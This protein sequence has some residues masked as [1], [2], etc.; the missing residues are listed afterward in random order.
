MLKPV[1]ASIN[2]VRIKRKILILYFFGILLPITGLV[3]FFSYQIKSELSRREQTLVE[4]ELTR[5]QLNIS[6]LINTA[7]NLATT[8]FSDKDLAWA[9]ETYSPSSKDSLTTIRSIDEQVLSNLMVHPFM[10]Q[11]NIYFDNEN[12]FETSY[13]H[14]LSEET[15]QTA[16]YQSFLASGQSTYLGSGEQKTQTNLY[17]I[18]RLN[19]LKYEGHNLIKIDISPDYIR[20]YFDSELLSRERCRI[21]LVTPD[22]LIALSNITDYP[23]QFSDV[24]FRKS[25]HPYT[26]EFDRSS[27]LSGWKIVA[28]P[29]RSL[30]YSSLSNQILFLIFAFLLVLSLSMLL[31]YGLAHSIIRRLEYMA[32]VMEQSHNDELTEIDIAMGS[33]EIGITAGCYNRMIQKV[34]ALMEDNSK[35]YQE[36]QSTNEELIATLEEIENKE[37]QIDE[38]VSVDKLTGLANRFSITR[39]IDNQFLEMKGTRSFAIGFLDIDNFKLINDSYGHDIGDDVIKQVGDRLNTFESDYIHTGRFG[40]D[41]FIITIK[42]YR[43]KKHLYKILEDIR[44]ALRE[45]IMLGG[46]S[47]TMTISMGVSLYGV[48][49]RRRHELIKLADIALYKAKEFGR[50]QIVFFESTMNQALSEKLKRQA[51]VREAVKKKEFVLFYQPYYDI[52]TR[53]MKGCEALLRWNSRCDF[54]ISTQEV[55]QYI[56]EMGL[57]IEFGFWIINEACAFAKKLNETRDTPLTVSINISALQLMQNDFI[58][59]VLQIIAKNKVGVEYIFLEMTESI[60]MDSIE[61]GFSMINRLQSA[62]ISISLDDFGTGYSS[63]KYF[64]ELPITTLKIDKSFIDHVTSNE[65]DEQLVDTMIQLA[66]NRKINVIAEGVE[67]PEQL[68]RLRK[69]NCDM[70]QGYLFSKPVCEADMLLLSAL[71]Q[72]GESNE[73]LS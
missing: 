18:R 43:D 39:F 4:G 15:R 59:K 7:S 73:N 1:K 6:T 20:S 35:A 32:N 52:E 12:L 64:K 40:G 44:I 61:K 53:T 65:Y 67:T 27:P 8:Y 48:H 41:E 31:F 13:A 3:L 66:H 9:L 22:N 60:L 68:E 58:D 16:W 21:F 30:L 72:E 33:D 24:S 51:C 45:P 10:K 50:D 46:I 37:R 49:S 14:F 47:F 34:R 54:K 19:L 57:M 23:K 28:A 62:G 42:D 26:M 69:M 2:D 38:L 55:V 5:I 36:L 17:L 29:A 11:I 71:G 63:L 56:E 70:V 25:S